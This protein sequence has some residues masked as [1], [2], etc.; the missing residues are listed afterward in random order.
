VSASGHVTHD[1]TRVV[2]FVAV[3]Q[4][5]HVAHHAKPELVIPHVHGA[6]FL[7]YPAQFGGVRDSSAV[8]ATGEQLGQL[9][10]VCGGPAVPSGAL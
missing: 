2:G 4:H 9:Q 10:V 1:S 3:G 7:R 5:L 8:A 6:T